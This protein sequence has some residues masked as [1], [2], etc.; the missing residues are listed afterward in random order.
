MVSTPQTMRS[1]TRRRCALRKN[2]ARAL[3]SKSARSVQRAA[4]TGGAL[5][6]RP[7]AAAAAC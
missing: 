3:A 2:K 5:A 7:T 4:R 6:A 1:A